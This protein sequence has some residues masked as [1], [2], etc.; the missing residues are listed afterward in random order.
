MTITLCL[1]ALQGR[2]GCGWLAAVPLLWS[3]IGGSA[4]FILNVPQDLGLVA[5]AVLWT[6]TIVARPLRA[7]AN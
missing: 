1:S 3:V 2:S 5:A 7:T 4:A 6:G